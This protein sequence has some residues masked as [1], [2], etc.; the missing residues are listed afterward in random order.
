MYEHL[1]AWPAPRPADS[2]AGFALTGALTKGVFGANFRHTI[3]ALAWQQQP[4]AG[5]PERIRLPWGVLRPKLNRAEVPFD[6]VRLA[7]AELDVIFASEPCVRIQALTF[8]KR[9]ADGVVWLFVPIL[10]IG[11]KEVH[12][13]AV[14]FPAELVGGG[15]RVQRKR[16]IEQLHR[17]L[18]FGVCAFHLGQ[19]V[20]IEEIKAVPKVD[21]R[22]EHEGFGNLAFRFA[23]IGPR[24]CTAWIAFPEVDTMTEPVILLLGWFQ[25]GFSSAEDFF[26]DVLV[27]AMKSKDEARLI[28]VGRPAVLH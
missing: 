20:M 16:L 11:M 18:Q 28:L 13:Y 5:R 17:A 4:Q 10:S 3:K 8:E 26:A 24:H 15:A 21:D 25:V 7:N 14:E 6:A 12:H 23:M 9:A 22:S 19:A 1:L 2:C 27:A